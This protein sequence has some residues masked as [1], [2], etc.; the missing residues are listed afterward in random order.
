MSPSLIETADLTSLA[1]DPTA[2]PFLDP[3]GEAPIRAELFGTDRL[4]H[5]ARQLAAAGVVDP[6]L[7]GDDLV[8]GRFAENGKVLVKTHRRIVGEVDRPEGRG[9]DADWLADNF[10]IVEDVL[11]EIKQDLPGGYYTELPKLVV[12]HV[13]G[14]PRVYTMALALVAHTDGELDEARIT[15]F[16]RAFQSV[17]PLRIGELWA[18]PT[19]LRLVLIENLR[20][21][22]DRMVRG[23]DERARADAWVAEH[24]PPRPDE[25]DEDAPAPAPD[26][27]PAVAVAAP[28]PTLT[29]PLVVRL[30]QLLRDR[31]ESAAP[32]LALL[33][34]QLAERGTDAGRVLRD[35]H[36]RQAANQVSVGNCVISLRL[37]S[38]VDWNVFFERNSGVE[39]ILRDDPA[40]VYARQDFATRDRYRRAVE[41]VARRSKSE[42][43]DVARRVVELAEGGRAS[44]APRDHVGYYLIDKGRAALNR[45]VGYAPPLG[46]R[47]SDLAL[48]HPR[49]VYFGA[50]G[51]LMV[52]LIGAMLAGVG[53]AWPGLGL[54]A[55]LVVALILPASEIAVGLV[56]H[57]TTLLLPPRKL[58]RLDFKEGIAA[59]CPT[60]VVVP[61]MLVRAD[62]ARVLLERLEITY[63]AN[64]D[65]NLRF[66]LLTD[67]ADAPEEHRP[68][69]ESL[70]R[71]ALD[72][73][74]ALNARYA[75]GGPDRFFLFHR[76][77]VWNESQGRWMGWERKRGKL[78][79]FNRLI[80]G[81]RDT[82]LLCPERRPGLAPAVPVRHHPRRRHDPAPRE[83][84]AAG[85]DDRPPAE[86]APVRP[87]RKSRVVEGYGVLQPR[88]SYHLF[89]A[90]R[91]RFAGLL[92]ASAGIDPYANG[93][94]RRLHGPVRPRELHRQ[95]DLRRR[96]LRGGQRPHLPRQP[97]PQPRPDRGELRPLRPGDRRRALRRLPAPLPRLR[98]PRAPLGPGRLATP[99]LARPDR[100]DGRREPKPNSAADP[101]AVEGPRQ[102]PPEP[103]P[104]GPGR[105]PGPRLDRPAGLP[106]A[107]DALRAGGPGPAGAP[108][109]DRLDLRVAPPR[110]ARRPG[111]D[112]PQPAGDGRP[113]APLDRLPRRPG[114][115]ASST[116]SAGRWPACS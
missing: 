63:L 116:R 12:G 105:A 28:F 34:A 81:D 19:M 90:T 68:E 6:S 32:T 54:L 86:L 23:W 85:R 100:P 87:E 10:H 25:D 15:R 104:A 16:L 84:Q 9:I 55:L 114:Q 40:G 69:D 13:R 48:A 108:A 67:F 93:G 107:L 102:P 41:K 1:S 37:L 99:P 8:L 98:P 33:E 88:V 65:P 14:Y 21:L 89:A 91:S 74:A 22:A 56:N 80:R 111:G 53:P 82:Q 44:G 109:R 96:R 77:R 39:V 76:R 57:F 36:R 112:R 29:D 51:L 95:G 75:A 62:S 73:V 71:G 58:A 106:L 47:L 11:R 43:E 115:A 4:E 27:P 30:V 7:K 94:L 17:V 110:F 97:D 79:E 24:L 60:I 103:G 101:G 66:A 2:S 61:S 64:P 38:A 35:E 5:L 78:S 52:G 92:A 49:P 46:E 113:V 20:R 45:E 26:A 83:R 70:I 50:I 18:V 72:G 42:E 59:D 31:G 3:R